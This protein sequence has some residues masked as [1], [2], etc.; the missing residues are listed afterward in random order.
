MR[1]GGAWTMHMRFVCWR[2]S[3]I[4]TVEQQA[5]WSGQLS[6]PAGQDS[7]TSTP[8][9][10]YPVRIIRSAYSR[11]NAQWVSGRGDG[12]VPVNGELV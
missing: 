10:H 3:G 5:G 8:L 4:A 9:A 1:V 7:D 6:V 12:R 11:C 2:P